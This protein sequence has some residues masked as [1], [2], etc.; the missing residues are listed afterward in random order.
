MRTALLGAA[1]AAAA[2]TMT[3]CGGPDPASGTTTPEPT[4]STSATSSSAP[5]SSSGSGRCPGYPTPACT[6]VPAG[7]KL[8]Q[9]ALNADDTYRV[10]QDGAVLDSVHLGGNLLITANHVTIKNSQIDG[11]VTDEYGG[12]DYSFT[13]T[14]TTVG[15]PTGC[16]SDSGVGEANFT[17]TG[18]LLQGNSDGFRDSG[19]NI[20]IRDS[21]VR[22]CSNPGDHSDGIQSYLGGANLVLDHNT[23]DQRFAKDA[24]APIFLTDQKANVRVT[25]NLVMGGTYSI[26]VRYTGGAVTVRNNRI[27]N[28]SWVYGPD[29][30][31][32]GQVSW[33]GNTLVTIDANYAVTSTVGPL[34]CA[35]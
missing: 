23:L 27:V 13:M 15:L 33:S 17:A 8:A 1:I 9:L 2:L 6:G 26:Q 31:N 25:N 24:T 4:T 19:D 20:Q 35:N 11:F 34:P 32:C 5:P 28:N 18:V 30:S 29:E 3:A 14:D 7:T 10:T 22:L 21:Y 16:D 12:V